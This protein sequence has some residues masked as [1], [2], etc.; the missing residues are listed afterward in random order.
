[1]AKK[2]T[3][4][5]TK[6]VSKGDPVSL[7]EFARRLEVSPS[8]VHEAIERG[9]IVKLPNGK[10]DWLTQAEVWE[11]NRDPSKSRKDSHSNKQYQ[12]LRKIWLGLKIDILEIEKKKELNKLIP[13]DAAFILWDKQRMDFRAA[14]LA[15]PSKAAAEISRQGAKTTAEYK[16]IIDTQARELLQNLSEIDTDEYIKAVEQLLPK[17]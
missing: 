8:T 13:I 3:K 12:D 7:R 2:L 16:K 1:M 15:M 11:T 4:K 6:K 5:S 17:S 9:R 14:T 10:I